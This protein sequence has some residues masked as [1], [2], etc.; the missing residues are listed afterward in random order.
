MFNGV[1]SAQNLDTFAPMVCEKRCLDITD[2]PTDADQEYT[3]RNS[4]EGNCICAVKIK[5]QK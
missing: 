2:G 3:Q 4:I 5:K 1:L